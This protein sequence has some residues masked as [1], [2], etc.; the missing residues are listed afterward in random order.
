MTTL[1]QSSIRPLRLPRIPLVVTILASF[2][3]FADAT[4]LTAD[5]YFT[6]PLPCSLTNGCDE[7]LRSVY[8][9]VGPVPLALLGAAYYLAIL[10]CAIQL[11]TSEHPGTIWVRALFYLS[12]AGLLVYG[13]LIYLQAAVIHAFCAYCL[14][15]ALFTLLIFISALVLLR[16][17]ISTLG[18]GSTDATN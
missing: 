4:Y 10:I 13:V 15:S 5:H 1:N 7:V 18:G 8:A 3:G 14:G 12:T 16:S 11:Y 17:R 9:T 6:L 2:L